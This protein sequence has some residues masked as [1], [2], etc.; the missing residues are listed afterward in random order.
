MLTV[1]F[2]LFV[3]ILLGLTGGGGG[4]VA[5]PILMMGLGYSFEE[6]KPIALLAIA[7]SASWA[8]V[9]GLNKGIVRYRAALYMAVIGFCLV[10]LGLL[11]ANYIPLT[12]SLTGFVCFLFYSA[13]QLWRKASSSTKATS[14]LSSA[15]CLVNSETHRLNWTYPC[16]KKLGFLGGSSGLLSG[17]LG[18]GGGIIIVPGM[19]ASSDIKLHSIIATSLMMVALVSISTISIMAYQGMHIPA[20]SY[21]FIV[22]S[23]L[24]LILGRWVIHYIP[25]PILQRICAAIMLCTA[26]IMMSQLI[27][28]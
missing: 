7:L 24:G 12:L 14:M 25:Q 20:T 28:K 15:P 13:I 5:L 22:M 9:Q 10:P 19:T 2:G 3:G 6:A 17:L 16:F 8:A 11:L 23:I 18:I 27:A 1:I 21:P 4:I 26:C